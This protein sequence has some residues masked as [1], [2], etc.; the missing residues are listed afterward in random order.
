METRLGHNRAAD[1]EFANGNVRAVV[2]AILRHWQ[3]PRLYGFLREAIN[4]PDPAGRESLAEEFQAEGDFLDALVEIATAGA[5]IERVAD[6]TTRLRRKGAVV[7]RLVHSLVSVRSEPMRECAVRTPE[8]PHSE[9]EWT[10]L[11]DVVTDDEARPFEAYE[12]KLTNGFGQD[13][14]DQLGDV[15]VSAKAEDRQCV[16]C[17]ATLGDWRQLDN[18]IRYSGIKLDEVLYYLDVT[19]MWVLGERPA[20]AR[21][22]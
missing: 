11:L 16:T 3:E 21:L 10:H 19:S 14:V 7:E 22:R 4:S 9:L 2:D 6:E 18:R 17:I 15:F 8:H 1:V 12:C 13:E 20:S 5:M